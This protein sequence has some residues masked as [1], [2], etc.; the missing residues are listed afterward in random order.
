MPI[1]LLEGSVTQNWYADDGNAVGKLSNL[2]TVLDKILSLAKNF[3]YH[4]KAFKC[5][6][7]A[8]N[9]KL[10]DAEK[11]FAK[12]GITIKAGAR[13]FFLL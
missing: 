5:Q 12:T 6:L 8:R 10:R 2:R 4:V 7:I 13:L 3:G 9:E 1:F 11:I